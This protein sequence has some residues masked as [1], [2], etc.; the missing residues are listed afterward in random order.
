M[1]S[2]QGI[3]GETIDRLRAARLA[4]TAVSRLVADLRAQGLELRSVAEHMAAAFCLSAQ[5]NIALIPKTADGEPDPSIL[6]EYIAM[7]VDAARERWQAAPPYPD[8]LRR[9]DR[10][11]FE[12]VARRHGI[13]LIVC[14][15]DRAAAASQPGYRL[16]GAYKLESGANAWTGSMGQRLRAELNLRLG[17]ELVQSGPHDTWAERLD[18]PE[19]DPLRGPQPPVLFFLPNGEV[20]VRSDAKGMELYCRFL[21]IDWDAAYA[22][23]LSQQEESQ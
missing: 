10:L 2:G 6:D 7:R 19:S 16:H 15:A 22:S 18:L 14:A 13:V 23:S 12:Q 17:Q 21:G 11:A 1:R 9:R 5:A 3:L 4:G 20:E 8:L